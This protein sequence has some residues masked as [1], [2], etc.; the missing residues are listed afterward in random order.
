MEKYNKITEGVIWKEVLFFFFPI[1]LSAFFQHFYTIVDGIIVGQTLGDIAFSAVGGSA[2]KVSTTL[3]NFFVGVSSGITAYTSISWGKKDYQ[4][5]K[6]V[7]CSGTLLFLGAGIAL[8]LLGWILTP[9]LLT[10]MGTPGET[11]VDAITYLRTFFVGLSFCILYNCFSGVLR[12][13]GDAK[14]ALYVLIFCSL[15]NIAL[16]LLLVVLWSWGVLGVAIATVVAQDL[17]ALLLGRIIFKNLVQKVAG[18]S[19]EKAM[20]HNICRIGIPAGLQ[21]IMYSLSNILVQS[22][23]NSFGY[24]TVSAW[25]AY[26]KLDNIVDLFVTALAGT[27]ITFVGQNLGAG[28]IKRIEEAV[29]QIMLLSYGI[30][31]VLVAGMM[32]FRQDLLGW[33]STNPEV[34]ALGGNLMFIIMP[35]Y[36]LGIPQQIYAQALRGLGK[37]FI[38]MVLTLVGIVGF[39]VLWVE[40]IFPHF[41]TIEILG[42]CYPLSALLM[43]VIFTI[44]YKWEYKKIH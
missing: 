37:S 26:V 10:A 4:G 8:S 22:A 23:I 33:F 29:N 27:V 35:C 14:T 30:V 5:L 39:R 9:Y 2:A 31:L 15:V 41:G 36:L 34:V 11:M 40:I 12:A 7:V 6:Q 43:S 18:P 44:Y 32:G 20:A 28:K 3:I 19:W 1:V 25:A 42:A 21:S 24:L 17:S 38:P 16:D 13:M